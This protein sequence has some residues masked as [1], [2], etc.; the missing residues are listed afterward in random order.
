MRLTACCILLSLCGAVPALTD[1]GVE[2]P[3]TPVLIELFTSQGC[4]SCPE[5]EFYLAKLLRTQPLKHVRIIAV[6]Q[7]VDYWDTRDWKDP[8]ASA[9]H[10]RRQR[11][12]AGKF[13]TDVYTPQLVV[14]G[15]EH[16]VGSRRREVLSSIYRAGR[17]EKAEIDLVAAWS[18]S[19]SIDL[20]VSVGN[21]PEGSGDLELWTVVT[22]DGLSVQVEAG[23]NRGRELHH[24]AVARHIGETG[25][26]Q[27]H[28]ARTVEI[29]VG[30]D[31]D[32]NNLRVVAFIQDSRS[33]RVIGVGSATPRFGAAP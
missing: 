32:R 3:R 6:S 28:Q 22:E 1:D 5:A 8:F 7:H 27:A 18:E 21:V 26:I 25:R 24:D 19:G 33:R 29:P 4:S 13:K 12:Y 23:E 14:D 9:E 15:T 30:A 11:R 2:V 16:Y 31:W 10:T 20:S 17:R